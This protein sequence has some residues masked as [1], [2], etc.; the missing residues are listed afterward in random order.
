MQTLY[1]SIISVFLCFIS[2]AEE[3][4]KTLEPISKTAK[5]PKNV[6]LKLMSTNPKY[7][8][9]DSVPIKVGHN[10]DFMKGPASQRAYFET[11]LDSKGNPVSYKRLFSGGNSPDG[12]SL[13]CYEIT[14]KNKTKVRL[15]IDMY[16]EKN[17]PK[18]QPAPVG[19]Y[20]KKD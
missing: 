1:V 2:N 4:L 12:N 9:S 20:K 14:L 18:L 19:F 8:Y 5:H 15:W 3:K 7:G 6:N 16:F 10:K 11:L 13:D 17:D